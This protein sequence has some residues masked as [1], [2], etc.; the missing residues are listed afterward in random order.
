MAIEW[1]DAREVVRHPE[2]AQQ[3]WY[4]EEVG[5]P[6]YPCAGVCI[7]Y[8]CLHCGKH[9]GPCD[10]DESNCTCCWCDRED[11]GA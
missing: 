6:E 3:C 10:H 11:R 5:V 4:A 9:T 1:R 7:R 2:C 8:A